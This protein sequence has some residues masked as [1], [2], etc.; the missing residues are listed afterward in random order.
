MEMVVAYVHQT[1]WGR[2]SI[3]AR[4]NGRWSAMF[5][6]EDLGSWAPAKTGTLMLPLQ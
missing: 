5:E 4:P 3:V 2:F 1:R 6:D